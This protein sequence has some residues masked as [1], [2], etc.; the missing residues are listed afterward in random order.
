[1]QK[2]KNKTKKDDKKMIQ[3]TNLQKNI[4]LNT[5]QEVKPKR[6]IKK[7]TINWKRDQS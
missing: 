6:I 5:N 7:K 1:M 3:K 2:R 4:N